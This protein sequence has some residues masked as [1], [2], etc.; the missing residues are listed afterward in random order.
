MM[1]GL[2]GSGKTTTTAKIARRLT[3]REKKKVLIA[4]L[5][6]RRP[7]AMEQLAV[8]GREAQIDTLPIVEG[9]LPPQD[10]PSA[11][12]RPPKLGG[13]DV[14]M[15]DTAGRTTLDDDM[16]NE[17][18]EVRRAVGPHEVAAGRRCAH[19]PGRRQSGARLRRARRL[20]RHRAH[21]R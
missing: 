19:R 2:Q 18:T 17:A 16:M 14:V 12:S 10:R 11:R 6:V 21:P 3:D 8:L 1:V 4:S 5:D 20:N 9:Q 15:L 13:Y 7:A